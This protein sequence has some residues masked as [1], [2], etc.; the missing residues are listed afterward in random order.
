[1]AIL[2]ESVKLLKTVKSK[3]QSSVENRKDHLGYLR[4]FKD[5]SRL[6]TNNKSIIKE[7]EMRVLE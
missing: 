3:R 7:L 2:L 4:S 6:M 5:S 1:M